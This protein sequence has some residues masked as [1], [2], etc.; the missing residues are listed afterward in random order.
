MC[1]PDSAL[2]LILHIHLKRG[3]GWGAGSELQVDVISA[4]GAGNGRSAAKRLCHGDT[5]GPPA[6]LLCTASPRT[7]AGF[8]PL[9]VL[10][11]ISPISVF[12]FFF[13]L[14]NNLLQQL[15]RQT[16]TLFL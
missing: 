16:Q 9:D 11:E 15:H 2:V 6:L 7:S 1:P 10:N 4:G 8:W 12:F 3:D 14:V 13:F 5:V